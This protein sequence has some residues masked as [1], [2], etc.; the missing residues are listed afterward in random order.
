MKVICIILGINI[1]IIFIL[2]REWLY[3]QK[4]F[5][6][7][8]LFN[9]GLYISARL[10]QHYGIGN[11]KFEAAL[12]I[13]VLQ[14]FLLL[15]LLVIYRALFKQNPGDTFWSMDHRKLKDGIFN[16]IFIVL[17]AIPT[18]LALANII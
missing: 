5:S 1:L 11:P 15:A 2:K 4:T 13:P 14:Q 12:K 3:Q 7:L 16:F 10:L 18:G 8:L 6:I 9:L 17:S